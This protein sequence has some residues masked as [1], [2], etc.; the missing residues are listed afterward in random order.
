MESDPSGAKEILAYEGDT[1]RNLLVVQNYRDEESTFDLSISWPDYVYVLAGTTE[2][3]DN[4][5][6]KLGDMGDIGRVV[7]P[8]HSAV[9]F[10]YDTQVA[11]ELPNENL[12][13]ST[14]YQITDVLNGDNKQTLTEIYLPN[15]EEGV[16]LS[17][18]Y[19]GMSVEEQI[20]LEEKMLEE[21]ELIEADFEKIKKD[22]EKVEEIAENDTN[23][24]DFYWAGGAAVAL[25]IIL[26]ATY[27]LKHKRH[28]KKDEKNN[29][30]A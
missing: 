26:L 13:L 8:A 17:E 16:D 15:F 19:Q 18:K 28:G 20:R 5:W 29:F 3:Y 10:R 30:S 24:N 22:V 27:L 25:I 11:G 12:I 4:G 6:Q 1:L 23:V 2:Q 14:S 21:R 9:F 7:V